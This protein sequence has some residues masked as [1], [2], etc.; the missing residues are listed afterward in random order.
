MKEEGRQFI[1]FPSFV[2]MMSYDLLFVV[3]IVVV[4]KT[5]QD[6]HP[7]ASIADKTFIDDAV[8]QLRDVVLLDVSVQLLIEEGA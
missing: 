3:F 2:F 6:T 8:L 5:S 4:N 7:V 1:C